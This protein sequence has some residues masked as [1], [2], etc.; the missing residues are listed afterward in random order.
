MQIRSWQAVAAAM[1]MFAAAISA[2]VHAAPADSN[3]A[4]TSAGDVPPGYASS[5]CSHVASTAAKYPI[6]NDPEAPPPL[7]GRVTDLTGALSAD[8]AS[9]LTN[10]LAELERKLGVQMAVLLVGSTGQSTIEQFATAV[11]DKWRLGERKLDNGLLLVAALN[12]RRVRIEV[13]YGLEG[14]IPDV[15]A[16]RIIREHIVPAFREGH[17]EAGVSDAVDALTREMTPPAM[18]SSETARSDATS[19]DI[20]SGNAPTRDERLLPNGLPVPKPVDTGSIAFW[21]AL[22]LAN[23]AIGIVAAWRKLRWQVVL[24]ASYGFAAVVLIVALPVGAIL[25]G[26]L[27]AVLAAAAFVPTGIGVGSCL[28]GI[29]LVRSAR[30]RKYAAIVFGTLFVLIAI[31]RAMGYS[32]GQVLSAVFGTLMVIGVIWAKLTG[33]NSSSSSSGFKWSSSSSSSDSS[34]TFR[35]G[36]GSS[37]GGGASDRW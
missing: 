30:V 31:G 3:S 15:V 32:A 37:G 11:F 5:A 17:V 10:R 33:G 35:G 18:A 28:L 20:T 16:G 29:G 25:N 14:A 2:P 9:D 1:V 22:G 36:G 34:D 21:F 23:V 19:D 12:D 4:V 27:D 13:G 26:K 7:K 24:P 6:A 8:C